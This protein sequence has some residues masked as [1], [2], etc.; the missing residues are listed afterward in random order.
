MIKLILNIL[1]LISIIVAYVFFFFGGFFY[2]FLLSLY[3][4][5]ERS[6]GDFLWIFLCSFILFWA[7]PLFVCFAKFT[8]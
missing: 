4:S 3:F 1:L 2:L 8:N 5:Y 7:Y 6:H